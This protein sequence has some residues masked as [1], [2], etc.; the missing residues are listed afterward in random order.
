MTN[1]RIKD[2]D[3]GAKEISVLRKGGKIDTV[4]IT[5]S[6]LEDLNSYLT[7]R[8]KIYKASDGDNEYL[9]IKNYRGNPE[10]LSNRAVEDIVYKYTKS[11]DKRMSPHKLR[12]TYATN[13]AE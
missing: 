11:F 13:L 8:K 12:H 1:L 6:S 2:I 5:P 10:P 9:F 4:S 7:V 3:F